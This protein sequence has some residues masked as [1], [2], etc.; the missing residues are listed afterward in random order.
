MQG[1]LSLGGLFIKKGQH[2]LKAGAA[3]S[4]GLASQVTFDGQVFEKWNYSI[5]GAV[6]RGGGELPRMLDAD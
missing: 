1:S 2:T 6:K 5:I 4:V 3:F